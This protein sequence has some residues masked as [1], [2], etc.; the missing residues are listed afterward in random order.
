MNR[1]LLKNITIYSG[2]NSR[3]EYYWMQYE[4]FNEANRFANPNR[5]P[6]VYTFNEELI[7]EYL[8]YAEVDNQRTT[9]NQTVR[10]VN[11]ASL[12]KAIEEGKLE[13]DARH[14]EDVVYKTVPLEGVWARVYKNDVVEN[15]AITH[16]KGDY[17]VSA[18]TG[19]P[20]PVTSITVWIPAFFDEQTNAYA[21]VESFDDNVRGILERGYK[22]LVFNQVMTEAEKAPEQKQ[23]EETAEQKRARLEAELANLA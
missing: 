10:V 3:G 15:G 6:R 2:K 16:K 12:K 22:R 18:T 17:I 9:P 21:P 8:P 23:E 19:E 4:L 1:R 20:I 13:W 5:L 14:I 11:D 7:K